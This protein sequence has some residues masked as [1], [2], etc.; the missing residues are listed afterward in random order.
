MVLGM[1][2]ASSHEPASKACRDEVCHCEVVAGATRVV[3]GR[4]FV[5]M[6]VR[7]LRVALLEDLYELHPAC[8]IVDVIY[9]HG[10]E[11]CEEVF[12]AFL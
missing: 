2:L 5:G 3:Q 12:R 4:Q 8:L 6:G 11:K 9:G 1:G 10:S 7:V